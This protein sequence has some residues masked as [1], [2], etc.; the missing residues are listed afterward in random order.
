MTLRIPLAVAVAAFCLGAVGPVFAQAP[1]DALPAGPG[2]DV[3]VRICTSCHDAS[4]F[5]AA[6]HTPEEWDEVITKMQGAGADMTAE[7]QA[8]ISA[9]LAKNLPKAAPPASPAP[10]DPKAPSA[11]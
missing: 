3:V 9:Y 8:A 7:E 10:A 11:R 4:E 6:R 1:E 5:S 2:K